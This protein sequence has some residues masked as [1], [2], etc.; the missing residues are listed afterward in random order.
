VKLPRSSQIFCQCA[1]AF[2]GLN[3]VVI[4]CHPRERGNPAPLMLFLVQIEAGLPRSR[5]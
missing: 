1:S 3:F 2:L 4:T 5:E